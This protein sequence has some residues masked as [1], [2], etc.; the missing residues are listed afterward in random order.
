MWQNDPNNQQQMYQQY[1]NAWDQGNYQQIPHQDAWQN[2]NQFMNNAP[3][4]MVEQVHQQYYQ[5]MPPQERGG[6][7][8]GIMG[9]LMQR[10]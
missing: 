1:A 10:G 3:P 5:Q 9:G 2:Y 4:Q 8:Q 7:L 6:L